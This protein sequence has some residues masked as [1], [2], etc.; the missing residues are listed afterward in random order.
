MTTSARSTRDGPQVVRYRSGTDTASPTSNSTRW[1][2]GSQTPAES[3]KN[4]T[5][6]GQLGTHIT[7]GRPVRSAATRTIN[8]SVTTKCS[9]AE[10]TIDCDEPGV[11]A[12]FWSELL[13]PATGRS[14][15]WF[16]IVSRVRGGPFINFQPVPERKAV[17]NRVH[18]DV[19]VDDIDAGVTLAQ[20]LG[21]DTSAVVS[22][23]EA[24]D[25]VLADPEGTELP[26]RSRSM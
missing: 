10:L 11:I 9:R 15:G 20:G 4:A 25:A 21:G 8:T 14:D 12:E 26:R 13:E 22:T 18:I 6:R 7:D 19:W 17:K 24:T 3:H 1:R 5:S 16:R 2:H 23:P